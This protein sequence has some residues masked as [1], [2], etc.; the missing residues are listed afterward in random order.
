[1]TLLKELYF[2]IGI[3]TCYK[4]VLFDHLQII[5]TFSQLEI[6]FLVHLGTDIPGRH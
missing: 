4:E 1:M 6:L 2:G 3:I 5:Q